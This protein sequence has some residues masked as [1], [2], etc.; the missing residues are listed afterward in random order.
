MQLKNYIPQH[1]KITMKKVMK[2]VNQEKLIN[3]LERKLLSLEDTQKKSNYCVLKPFPEIIFKC[4][5]H[6]HQQIGRG[7]CFCEDLKTLKTLLKL[8]GKV[9]FLQNDNY[10]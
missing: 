7:I 8:E 4:R 2:L 9:L 3:G 10:Y 6:S 1:Y 5:F